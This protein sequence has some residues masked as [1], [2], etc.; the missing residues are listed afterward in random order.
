MS[1]KIK[2]VLA[3]DGQLVWTDAELP[4]PGP[5][6]V[7]IEIHFAGLNRADL[8]QAKGLYPPP[9]GASDALGLECSGI[10]V[11]AGE[12]VAD[13]LPINTRVMA[14][15]AGGGY[16]THALVPA[17]QVVM[18]T[19]HLGLVE[20]AGLLETFVTAHS[21]LFVFARALEEEKVLIHGGAGGVGTAAI[22]LCRVL[23]L[24]TFV[25]VGDRARGERC[26]KLGAEGFAVYHDETSFTDVVRAAGNGWESGPDVILDCV[27]G[28]YLGKHLDLIA[29]GGRLATIG[30]Q[31]GRHAQLDMGLLLKKRIQVMGST[32]RARTPEEKGH[33]ID[34]LWND[35]GE[36]F[37]QG[38][39]RPHIFDIVDGKNPSAAH[40]L[41]G[42][43][44]KHF[45]KIVLDMRNL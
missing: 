9:P 42:S 41:L 35:V 17:E 32:L 11:E 22:D 21:N 43:G 23:G 26:V 37:E 28:A 31:G 38:T 29:P 16:A 19:K 34:A 2:H 25:T 14:L 6:E 27:G 15:L 13:D 3:S 10:V 44:G 24:R 5:D 45:G 18:L 8:L 40:D 39:L 12:D 20:G 30:L 1:T 33:L 4:N 36:L 7:L